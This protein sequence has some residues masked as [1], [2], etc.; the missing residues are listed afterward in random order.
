MAVGVFGYMIMLYI[1]YRTAAAPLSSGNTRFEMWL[2]S[3]WFLYVP[4]AIV[5]DWGY[6]TKHFSVFSSMTRAKIT[7]AKAGLLFLSFSACI[8]FLMLQLLFFP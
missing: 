1:G 4:W 8:F 2:Y 7:A 3:I 5:T 6:Y